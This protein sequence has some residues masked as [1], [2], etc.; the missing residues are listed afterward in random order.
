MQVTRIE[1]QVI[2]PSVRVFCIYCQL[3]E[4]FKKDSPR[5]LDRE[6]QKR[7]LSSEKRKTKTSTIANRDHIAVSGA[8]GFGFCSKSDT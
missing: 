5:I 8:T 1:E 2:C 4:I 3:P 6:C 7:S